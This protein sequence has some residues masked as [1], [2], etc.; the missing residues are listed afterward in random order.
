MGPDV[1]ISVPSNEA[2]LDGGTWKPSKRLQEE[3]GFVEK[4]GPLMIACQVLYKWSGLMPFN[5]K[6]NSTFN[7]QHVLMIFIHA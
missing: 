3:E 7:A 2:G 4:G 1:V 5:R 6:N